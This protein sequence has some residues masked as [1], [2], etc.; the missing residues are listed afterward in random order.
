MACPD[1][2][3][4]HVHL[5]T[6]TGEE[7]TLHGLRTYVAAPQG[8]AKGVI[9]YI[10]DAFGW[11]FVNNRLLADSYAKGGFLVYLPDFM[12]GASSILTYLT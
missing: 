4:G 7:T 12:S 3:T 5:G 1:C 9:V 8:A 11:Q 10:P 2:F 6:P